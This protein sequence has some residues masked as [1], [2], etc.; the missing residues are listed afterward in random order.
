MHAL[1]TTAVREAATRGCRL[2]GTSAPPI[3]RQHRRLRQAPAGVCGGH[4][5]A[6]ACGHAPY[7]PAR[8]LLGRGG[9]F[10]SRTAPR[11]AEVAIAA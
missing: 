4:T 3:N 5:T 11:S 2:C 8:W 6:A 10:T 7:G 1:Q 9:Y